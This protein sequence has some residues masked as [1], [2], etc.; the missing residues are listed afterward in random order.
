MRRLPRRTC[1]LMNR[2]MAVALI[3]R[4][5]KEY[6]VDEVSWMQAPR[7]RVI[8][9]DGG[10]S[11]QEIAASNHISVVML[12]RLNPALLSDRTPPGQQSYPIR[13]PDNSAEVKLFTTRS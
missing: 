4:H 3:A 10:T 6:G 9:V 5:A 7:Y 13:V 2:F 8:A 1:A 12:R 11:L